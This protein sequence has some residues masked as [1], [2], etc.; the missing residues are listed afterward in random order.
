MS[1]L[2]GDSDLSDARASRAAAIADAGDLESAMITG[3]LP[4]RA[5]VTLSE[6]V[7][8]RLLRQGVRRSITALGHRP[9]ALGEVPR[10]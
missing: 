4:E 7:V 2:P 3:G 10:G 6:A 1:D 9:T 5:D 8:L